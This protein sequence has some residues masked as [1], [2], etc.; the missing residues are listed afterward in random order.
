MSNRVL[1]IPCN[2]ELYDHWT[3]RD[4]MTKVTEE[5]N[6]LLEA[7]VNY[8]NDMDS[9]LEKHELACEA[10]DLIIATTSLLEK[11]GFNEETR[12]TYMVLKNTS[13]MERDGGKR[14]RQ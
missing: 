14:I 3:V 12:Q 5:Y 7:F 2:G 1:P 10:T 9:G 11:A 13:N 6:E 8:A 4:Y